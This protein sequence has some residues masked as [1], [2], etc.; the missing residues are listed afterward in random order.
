MREKP[1]G[2]HVSS[3]ARLEV[4]A[5]SSFPVYLCRVSAGFPAPASDYVERDI[6]LNDWLITNKLTTYI[7]R[8]EGDSMEGIGMDDERRVRAMRAVDEINRRHGRHTVRPLAVGAG[9]GWDMRRQRLSP[10]YTTRLNEALRVK[11]C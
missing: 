9:R 11:A 2:L 8:V 1:P 4:A 5:G 7:V 10:R 3:V 6:D